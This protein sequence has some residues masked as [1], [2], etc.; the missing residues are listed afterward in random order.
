M[1]IRN[2]TPFSDSL[3]KSITELRVD[4]ADGIGYLAGLKALNGDSYY[5]QKF[6]HEHDVLVTIG[7]LHN[8]TRQILDDR[9]TFIF[10]QIRLKQIFTQSARKLYSELPKY[11]IGVH[12][13]NTD[14]KNDLKLI[15]SNIKNEAKNTG[16]YNV[17]IATDDIKAKILF[18]K[19]LV[20]FN[21]YFNN[22]VKL[23]VSSGGLHYATIQQLALVGQTKKNQHEEFWADLFV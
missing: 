3:P 7:H 9:L 15:L 22:N 5:L 13:R 20:G 1:A 8:L 18:E 4:F 2:W 12:Y 19:N 10:S 16:I 11:Y 14:Y 6:I 17:F 21:V 23:E